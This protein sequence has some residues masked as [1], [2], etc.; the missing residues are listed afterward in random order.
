MQFH[1]DEQL[2]DLEEGWRGTKVIWFDA[3]EARLSC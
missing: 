2:Q 3:Y 1:I